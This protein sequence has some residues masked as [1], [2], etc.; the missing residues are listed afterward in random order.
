M[1]YAI[2]QSTSCFV[3]VI[4]RWICGLQVNDDDDDE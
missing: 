4:V 3:F 1:L 2:G